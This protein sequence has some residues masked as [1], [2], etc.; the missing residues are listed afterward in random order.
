[1]FAKNFRVEPP[2][3][4][5]EDLWDSD[6]D[7][8]RDNVAKEIKKTGQ[9][10]GVISYDGYG[11]EGTRVE[12]PTETLGTV[13][14]DSMTNPM[15]RMET[16]L[17]KARYKSL[18]NG[19]T[20]ISDAYDF[21]EHPGV[22]R[23]AI[24]SKGVGGVFLDAYRSMGP[25][26]PLNMLG[27]LVRPQGTGKPYTMIIPPKVG[28][29]IHPREIA[30]TKPTDIPLEIRMAQRPEGPPQRTYPEKVARIRGVPL[31]Q[32]GI[33]YAILEREQR[34]A[35]EQAARERAWYEQR[36]QYGIRQK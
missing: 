19:Y 6:R 34:A 18:P 11:E 9:P 13:L 4:R 33:G 22:I 14:Y 35:R 2:I 24:K 25:L 17:G 21:K 15:Y 3:L 1:M 31:S 32:E 10:S 16:T 26:G 36:P 8:I 7:A 28:M 29:D 12:E 5:N 30:Q 27:G 23:Q 20:E